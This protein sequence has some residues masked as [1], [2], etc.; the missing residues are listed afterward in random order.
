MYT[1]LQLGHNY[2]F[3]WL[4]LNLLA[5]YSVMCLMKVTISLYVLPPFLP[6]PSP[7]VDLHLRYF[8]NALSLNQL[9]FWG[10]L[11]KMTLYGWVNSLVLTEWKS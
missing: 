5:L 6:M 8:L 1:T 11:T 9:Q 2:C 3:V 10:I 4:F 7:K